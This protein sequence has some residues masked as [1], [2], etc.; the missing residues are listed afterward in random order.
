M[1]RACLVCQHPKRAELEEALVSGVPHTELARQFGVSRW[2]VDRHRDAHLPHIPPEFVT[3]QAEAVRKAMSLGVKLAWIERQA[4]LVFRKALKAGKFR[5]AIAALRLLSDQ[6]P[7]EA[8][9]A[10]EMP[11]DSPDLGAAVFVLLERIAESRPEIRPILAEGL[12]P[13]R[14]RHSRRG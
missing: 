11:P 9:L 8:K 5:D 1:P 7:Y 12:C 6:L 3:E 2:S 4:I 14:A 10:G 13:A